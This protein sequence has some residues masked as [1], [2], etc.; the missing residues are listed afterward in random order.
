[1]I[2]GR[3]DPRRRALPKEKAVS[4]RGAVVRTRA[5]A[6]SVHSNIPSN[7][8]RRSVDADNPVL[9]RAIARTEPSRRHRFVVIL[10]RG[11]SD[12]APHL[13]PQFARYAKAHENTLELAAPPLV[14]PGGEAVKNDPVTLVATQ[15]WLHDFSIDR[16]SAV[17]IVGGGA[18]LDMAG[19]AAATTH[20]GVRV[21]RVPTTVLGQGDSGVGVKNGVNAFGKKNF[22]GTFA[23]PFAVINDIDYLD[24][25][26]L[27]DQI[28]GMAEAVKVALIK[29][30]SFFRFIVESA[31]LLSRGERAPIEALVERCA[32]LHL[33]HIRSGETLSSLAASAR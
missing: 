25:L 7:F 4:F 26:P 13:A 3:H 5:A 29:D 31:A 21:V 27:R 33:E 16:H 28:A 12:A 24:T 11:V 2:Q 20:R 32:G 8:T 15:G 6:I 19:Y 9:A 14:V 17:V 23:P 22:L 18:V 10:D 1:M 30:A